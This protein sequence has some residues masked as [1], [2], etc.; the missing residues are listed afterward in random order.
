MLCPCLRILAIA[1]GGTLASTA[2]YTQN[3]KRLGEKITT[4]TGWPC[5]TCI[6]YCP[7]H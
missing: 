3:L 7:I 5:T 2:F 1:G 4:G 6:V